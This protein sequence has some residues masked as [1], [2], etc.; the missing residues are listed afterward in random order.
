MYMLIYTVLCHGSPLIART[1]EER[2][3]LGTVLQ[4]FRLSLVG[5]CSFLP[6]VTGH[7]CLFLTPSLK[8]VLEFY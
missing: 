3:N 6:G 4:L 8:E 5:S 7:F 1:K 2:G